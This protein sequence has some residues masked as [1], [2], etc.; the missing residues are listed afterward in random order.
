MQVPARHGHLSTGF[1]QQML[2]HGIESNGFAAGECLAGSE[3]VIIFAERC[4]VARGFI[5]SG[6]TTKKNRAEVSLLATK[7]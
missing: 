5:Y 3:G 6:R 2:L 1:W 7:G 4:A